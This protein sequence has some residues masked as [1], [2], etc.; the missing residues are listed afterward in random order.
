MPI[1]RVD[2][3][4]RT[5]STDTGLRSKHGEILIRGDAIGTALVAQ[6]LTFSAVVINLVPTAGVIAVVVNGEFALAGLANLEN[7]K[8]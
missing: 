5:D 8:R 6:R 1:A 2:W 4:P 3:I 7:S